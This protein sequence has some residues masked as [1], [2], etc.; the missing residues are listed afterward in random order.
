MLIV[1]DYIKV[2]KRVKGRWRY[3]YR[4]IYKDKGKGA[5]LTKSKDPSIFSIRGEIVKI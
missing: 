1:I 4:P 5:G 2:I 3:I